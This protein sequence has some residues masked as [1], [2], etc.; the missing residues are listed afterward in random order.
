M[1]GKYVVSKTG[2]YVRT[3]VSVEVAISPHTLSCQ[4]LSIPSASADILIAVAMMLLVRD[5]P[6]G[7]FSA[8][9]E[10]LLDSSELRV[11]SSPT[12]Y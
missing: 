8:L 12:S 4:L 10:I 11:A 5:H 1:A 3:L 9:T 7:S 2:I 6:I